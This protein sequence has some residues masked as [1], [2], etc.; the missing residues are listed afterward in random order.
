MLSKEELRE[1]IPLYLIG[2]LS[3]KERKAFEEGLKQFPDLKKEVAEFSAIKEFYGEIEQEIP[4]PSDTLYLRIL[5]KVRRGSKIS[6]PFLLKGY[7]DGL[8]Q[9]LKSLY[10]SPRLSWGVVA[11]ELA[12]IL[13]L[14]FS[15]SNGERLKTL[16]SK[17]RQSGEGVRIHIVFDR[18]AKEGEIREILSRV[19]GIIIHGPSPEGLYTIEVKDHPDIDSVLRILKETG[20]IKFAESAF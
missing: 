12:I 13:F 17:E 11:V 8:A 4:V 18:D 20:I 2:R 16:T 10:W 6:L 9:F 14:V 1:R 19:G 3:E 5:E 15:L 7:I